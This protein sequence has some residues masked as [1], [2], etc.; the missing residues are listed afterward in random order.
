MVQYMWELVDRE[1]ASKQISSVV[2]KCLDT[3]VDGC[4]R[5]P[6]VM[7]ALGMPGVGKTR[8]LYV[9]LDTVKRQL[10]ASYPGKTVVVDLMFT[11]N[12]A[13]GNQP[14]EGREASRLDAFLGWRVLHR[15][16]FGNRRKTIEDFYQS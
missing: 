9:L 6:Q 14:Q 11:L 10:S 5:F 4:P 1:E 12:Q 8:M 15:Y 2:S 7:L 3:S 13:W 16:F